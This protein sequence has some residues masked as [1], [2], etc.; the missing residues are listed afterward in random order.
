MTRPFSRRKSSLVCLAT[1]IVLVT[2]VS[3]SAQPKSGALVT[4][5]AESAPALVKQGQDLIGGRRFNEAIDVLRKAIQLQP[6]LAAAHV[7]LAIALMGVGQRD[8]AM[9]E[10]IR[11]I[12][13]DPNDARAYVAQGNINSSMRR[14]DEAIAAYKQ[15]VNLDPN[16]LNAYMNLGL[17][18]GTTNRF[19]ESAEAFQQAL[20]LDPN[21]VSALNGLGIAQFRMGQREEGIQSVK[22]AVRLNPRF[23]DG[24]LN[25]AR[26]YHGMGR[27][28]DAIAAFTEVT[29]IVPKWPQT[30]FERSQDNFYVGLND[31]AA[32]DA[33]TFLELTDWHSDRAQYMAV[34]A[35]ISYRRAGKTAEAKEILELSAKRSNTSS[36]PYRIISY[37]RGEVTGDALVSMA[38]GSNDRLTEAH[39]YIGLDLL[40]KDQKDLAVT[41]FKWVKERGNRN[42]VEYIFSTIELNRLEG[43]K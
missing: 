32:S 41:H 15:A 23:V 2:L 30:Y 26:W 13:L 3:V 39:G 8:E 38:A 9:A 12:E 28:Q 31:A 14:Y 5:S 7:Q 1:F 24:Y 20:R 10:T 22:Q 34:F 25:L 36:W 37:L 40:L 16:Y 29:K 18:Y 4:Q 11:A 27:Y 42:F 35:N 19:P 17:F 6:N 33:Q 21:N 43:E